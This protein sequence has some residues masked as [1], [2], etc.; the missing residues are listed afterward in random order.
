[1]LA[2]IASVGIY[3]Y[4]REKHDEK[5]EKKRDLLAF[6]DEANKIFAGERSRDLEKRNRDLEERSRKLEERNRDLEKAE[7]GALLDRIKRPRRS[8]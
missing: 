3:G 4:L 8:S 7:Q 1:M 5:R 6:A 2:M